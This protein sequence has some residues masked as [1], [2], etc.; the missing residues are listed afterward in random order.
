MVLSSEFIIKAI[1]KQ[2]A[3][4]KTVL[5]KMVINDSTVSITA[6][7]KKESLSFVWITNG[8]TTARMLILMLI[9]IPTP[10][11][12]EIKNSPRKSK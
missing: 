5:I 7:L 4:D 2:T 12:Y 3:A 11:E 6:N 10:F 9:P 8:I 1:K